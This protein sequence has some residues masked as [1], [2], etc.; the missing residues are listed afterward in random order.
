LSK[1][2]LAAPLRPSAAEIHAAARAG[3][4]DTAAN[5][6][7]TEHDPYVSSEPAPATSSGSTRVSSTTFDESWTRARS[8]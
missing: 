6:P 3:D 8:G 7:F 5:T 2:A 1:R 4:L